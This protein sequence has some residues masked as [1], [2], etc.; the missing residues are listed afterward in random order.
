MPS[1]SAAVG[2]RQPERIFPDFLSTARR[3]EP[4]LRSVPSPARPSLLYFFF[5]DALLDFVLSHQFLRADHEQAVIG[6]DHC[7]H[8][9]LAT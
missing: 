1:N 2:S 3:M 8:Q 6:G 7:P 4:T 5:R 9:E